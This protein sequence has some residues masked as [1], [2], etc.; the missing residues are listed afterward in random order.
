MIQNSTA[1]ADKTDDDH[2]ESAGDDN[3]SADVQNGI[4][5]LRRNLAKVFAQ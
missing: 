4:D 3:V 1:A 2:S 5:I